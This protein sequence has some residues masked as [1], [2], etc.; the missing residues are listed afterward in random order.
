M[1]L[2]TGGTTGASKAVRRPNVLYQKMCEPSF[3][4]VGVG[5]DDRFFVCAPMFH[6]GGD[7]PIY[8]ML[9]HGGSVAIVNGF[10]TSRFWEDIRRYE[11]TVAWIH[12]AM[13]QFLWEQPARTARPRPSASPRDAG[14]ACCRRTASSPSASGPLYTVYGMTEMPPGSRSSTLS[15]T[16]R[17]ASRGI[18]TSRLRLVDEHDREV[19]DGTPGELLVRHA[20]PWAVTPGYL[21]NP[22]ATAQVWRNGWF[23]S[24]DVFVRDGN[25]D[26]S[27]VGRV[28]DSLRRRGENIS[29]AEVEREL[30]A[31]PAIAEAAVV[32]SRSPS[33]RR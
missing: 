18:P 21:R 8:S 16:R 9:R 23:H 28:K 26:Y 7:V 14:A 10:S 29:A 24:G 3:D 25:G 32:G 4:N 12:S 33:S 15:T 31:H 17:S 1:I 11:C 27:L 20:V 22:S 13:A 19:P 2:F 5:A 30:I 6:G